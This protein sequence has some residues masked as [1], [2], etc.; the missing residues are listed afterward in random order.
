MRHNVIQD[1]VGGVR[2]HRPENAGAL[3]TS[4]LDGPAPPRRHRR[5]GTGLA[6]ARNGRELAV[7]R[8]GASERLEFGGRVATGEGRSANRQNCPHETRREPLTE[9]LKRASLLVSM[10]V[11]VEVAS[12]RREPYHAD[13]EECAVLR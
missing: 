3:M 10:Y 6:A 5:R 13:V 8:V 11:R 1:A 9:R 2:F 4:R 7:A 12:Q